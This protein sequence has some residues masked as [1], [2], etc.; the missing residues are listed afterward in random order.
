[1]M[2]EDKIE[3]LKLKIN[4]DGIDS[5]LKYS[6]KAIENN[7]KFYVCAPNAYVT[8]K[9][10]EDE[11]LL[12]II[13]DA[14]IAI[15]DGMS[16]VWVSNTFKKFRLEKISGYKFFIEFSEVANSKKNV[17]YYFLGGNNL[18][19]LEKIRSRLKLEFPDIEVRGMYCPPYLDEMPEDINKLIV[20]DINKFSP[21]VLW[22]GLSAPKQ[23]KWI[24]KNLNSINIKMACG[25]GAVFDFYSENIKRAPSWIRN[26]GLEWLFRMFMEPRRL[27]KK[28]MLYNS[29][30]MFLVIKDIVFKYFRMNCNNK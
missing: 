22:V 11:E 9:A 28:Y 17:S 15:A 26:T 25:I 4:K 18:K 14:K 8:V 29:K 27:F 12:A 5:L 3:I 23:E 7:E 19:T 16:L 24:Y 2:I 13:N 20:A 6:L 1:M 30:F 21:D 10:N